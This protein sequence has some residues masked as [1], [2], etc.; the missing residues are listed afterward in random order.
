MK[1]LMF[2]IGVFSFLLIGALSVDTVNA[3]TMVD[4][5]PKKEVK[6]QKKCSD[7]TKAKCCP[8]K[9][10]AKCDDKEGKSAS[11]SSTKKS[12]PDKK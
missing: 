10:A 12:D 9:K 11:T 3:N 6:S 2:A 4:D 5:P 1:K 8:S 7:A